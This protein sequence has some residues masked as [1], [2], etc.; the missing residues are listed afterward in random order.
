MNDIQDKNILFLLIKVVPSQNFP[1][2]AK[3]R[4]SISILLSTISIIM[5]IIRRLK[6]EFLIRKFK[7]K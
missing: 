4:S 1:L 7:Y 6:T 5:L 2:S 3:I